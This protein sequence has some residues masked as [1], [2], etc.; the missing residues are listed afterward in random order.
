LSAKLKSASGPDDVSVDLRCV[1]QD[2]TCHTVLL[3]FNDK[4]A[5]QV[6]KAF[7]VFRTA[8]VTVN[9]SY[10]GFQGE[11]QGFD[12]LVTVLENSTRNNGQRETP[13]IQNV[14]AESSTV[15]FGRSQFA[16]FAR[17]KNENDKDTILPLFGRLVRPH[18]SSDV[19]V[20]LSSPSSVVL[21]DTAKSPVDRIMRAVTKST[22]LQ[23][24]GRGSIQVLMDFGA[25][26]QQSETVVLT[27]LRSSQ[28]LRAL[29]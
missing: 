5:H 16:V 20:D 8:P 7:A 14:I 15:I 27:I 2:D 10:D 21:K 29:K 26:Q 23:N 12:N 17:I 6:R 18:H 9:F 19:G 13:Y 1:D 25:D 28:Q 3:T 24:N 11:N 22:L 4:S